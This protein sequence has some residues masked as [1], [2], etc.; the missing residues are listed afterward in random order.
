MTA[1]DFAPRHLV[2]ATDLSARCD[3]ARDRA[4]MLARLWKARLTAVHVL[5]VLDVP[6][7]QASR[8]SLTGASVRAERLLRAD[9]TDVNDIAVSFHIGSGR[10]GD[11]VLDIATKE[12]CDL[13][14]TGIAGNEPMGQSLLGSTVTTVARAASIPVLIVKRPPTD[15]YRRVIVASD[16]SEASMSALTLA[17]GLFSTKELTLFHAFDTPFHT[18]ANNPKEYREGWR[19]EAVN[20]VRAFLAQANDDDDLAMK[21]VVTDGDPGP[22]IADH[23]A[24]ND[25]DLVVAGK[26]GRSRVVQ[27]LLGSVVSAI[28]DEVPC[29]VLIVPDK[30][31]AI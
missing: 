10:P 13:I 20:R 11:F 30:Y 7:D 9:F 3:R 22:R 8:P 5:D 2:F 21:L 25:I 18:W 14:V 1:S 23:V 6:N 12:A 16:L 17:L 31:R 4:V 19:R 27:A 26:H 15:L 29:D 24:G 28:L